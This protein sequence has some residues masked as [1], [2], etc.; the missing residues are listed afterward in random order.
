M[1]NDIYKHN[2][3]ILISAT[4]FV[5]TRHTYVSNMGTLSQTMARGWSYLGHLTR[6]LYMSI[7][8]WPF[9]EE[10]FWKLCQNSGLSLFLATSTHKRTPCQKISF[11]EYFSL[12]FILLKKRSKCPSCLFIQRGCISQN[13][14]WFCD[15]TTTGV[16]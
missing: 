16:S 12:S 11:F 7:G 1:K 13:Y 10:V 2:L 6:N 9:C 15:I 8:D 4:L 14:R 3:K 5:I